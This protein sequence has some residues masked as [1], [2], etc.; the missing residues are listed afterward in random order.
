[1][2]YLDNAATTQIHPY[3]LSE[4]MPYLT[5]DYGNVGGLYELGKRAERAVNLARQQV[6][7]FLDT[8]PENIIFTSGGCEAN[9][10]AISVANLYTHQSQI[11]VTGGILTSEIE[12]DSI[13][14][15]ARA[16]NERWAV[17]PRQ[18]K[19]DI[20]GRVRIDE[21]VAD[22]I[23]NSVMVSVML[24]NNET[25]VFND[26]SKIAEICQEQCTVFHVDAVQAAGH[27][28]IDV[29]EIGCD[30]LSISSHKIHGPKGV[31]ALY[32]SDSILEKMKP[33]IHGGANQEFGKRG[34]TEN[35]AGIVGFGVACERLCH[36]ELA[37]SRLYHSLRDSF[38]NELDANLS[39]LWSINGDLDWNLGKTLSVCFP[40]VDA[41][42]LILMLSN[43]GICVSA[44]SACTSH[45]S[46]PSH[47]LKAMG[48]SDEDARSSI[49]ISFSEFNTEPEVRGAAKRIAERVLEL[50][51]VKNEN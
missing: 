6:A 13:L 1:M 24:E 36:R 38:I 8:K 41:E 4:M 47:V 18:F 11:G 31:G 44:G 3:V 37:T 48:L 43:D 27:T 39:S 19:T 46:K 40:N 2:I 12:H 51:E 20:S 33:L 26:V 7:R 45:E 10:I 50:R 35:V 25:G 21:N 49:R 23:K 28:I 9:S 30:M 15:A 34:G 14:N 16:Y 29:G 5:E 22:Y 42:T 17:C 32:V